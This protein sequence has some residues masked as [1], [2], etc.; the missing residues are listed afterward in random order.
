[1]SRGFP[2]VEIL[3]DGGGI[4]SFNV[5]G[6]VTPVEFTHAPASNEVLG[7]NTIKFLISAVGNVNQLLTKFMDLPSLTNGIDLEIGMNETV[8]LVPGI[9]KTN[10]DVFRFF[11]TTYSQGIIGTANV[12]EG[13]LECSPPLI[14]DGSKGDYFR[15]RI[16]DNLTGLQAGSVMLIGKTYQT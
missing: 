11:Q 9:V 8:R 10:F 7:V 2:T 1:M 14:L 16:R 4:T 3:I 6:S 15:I 13:I 5:N 12:L